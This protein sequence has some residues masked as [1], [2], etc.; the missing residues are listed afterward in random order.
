[1]KKQKQELLLT[2]EGAIA[3]LGEEQ[4]M[5]KLGDWSGLVG[6][7]VRGRG[8]S[9]AE[10]YET[11]DLFPTVASYDKKMD[12][13]SGAIE[14]G[15]NWQMWRLLTK[16]ER[17]IPVQIYKNDVWT[18]VGVDVDKAKALNPDFV[19]AL[20]SFGERAIVEKVAQAMSPMAL[21]GGN[22]VMDVLKKL[23][24]GTNLAKHLTLPADT[25]LAPNDRA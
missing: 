7:L 23:L 22:S 15:A 12:E 16:E 17:S 9:H 4:V 8:Y 13:K 10:G 11:I 3:L 14:S 25:A 21:I 1:M 20:N 2:E 6:R 24:E 18:V 5:S 19:A